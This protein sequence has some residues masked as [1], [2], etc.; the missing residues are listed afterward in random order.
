MSNAEAMLKQSRSKRVLKQPEAEADT[1]AEVETDNGSYA[2]PL[3][4]DR[5]NCPH[6]TNLPEQ[7]AAESVKQLDELALIGLQILDPATRSVYETTI[8][9]VAERAMDGA[10]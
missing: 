7:I 1:E 9:L 4:L 3:S 10:P 6:V 8:R 2:Y 5:C